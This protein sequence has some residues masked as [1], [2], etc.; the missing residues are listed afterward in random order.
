M[1]GSRV[2]ER[3]N[4]P[5]KERAVK[6]NQKEHEEVESAKIHVHRVRDRETRR[7]EER[8]ERLMKKEYD[9][10]GLEKANSGRA[11]DRVD[12]QYEEKPARSSR[13]KHNEP[14]PQHKPVDIDIHLP[15][16]T[17]HFLDGD[18]TLKP[19]PNSRSKSDRINEAH[20]DLPGLHHPDDEES[21]IT[22]PPGID[23]G[24]E[25]PLHGVHLTRQSRPSWSS[26]SHY[27]DDDDEAS[28][29]T[30]ESDNE[31]RE[32]LAQ[33]DSGPT[34]DVGDEDGN[35]GQGGKGKHKPSD[36]EVEAARDLMTKE[37]S[38]RIRVGDE[39]V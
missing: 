19:K 38:R 11:T 27:S 34:W 20:A 17:Q 13:K 3:E 39:I 35:Q 16:T 18:I 32:M 23:P 10:R 28:D 14:E 25:Q 33:A 29:G 12:R 6:S 22:F 26:D 36:G 21:V 7:P 9:E 2:G 15:S 8:P 30:V 31:A 4:R 1:S 5:S 37:K 24:S